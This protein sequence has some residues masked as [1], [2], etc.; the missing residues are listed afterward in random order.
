MIER[1]DGASNGGLPE[2]RPLARILAFEDE[3]LRFPKMDET[4]RA[5]GADM[6]G[7]VRDVLDGGRSPAEKAYGVGV[8]VHNYFRTRGI[9]LTSY[10]LRALANE[11]IEPPHVSPPPAVAEQEDA[12]EE[13]EAE[14]ATELVSFAGKKESEERVWAGDESTTSPP[15]VAEIAFAAPPS[16]LVNVVGREA[17]SFDRLLMKVVE[18]AAP[19]V[20]S[21]PLDRGLA[22]V[23]I[24]RT[25][26][27][28]LRRQEATLP[29]GMR[30][31]LSQM[32]FSEICG[33]GLLD[34]LWADR[35]IRAVYVDGPD[36]VYVERDGVREPAPETFRDAAHLLDIVRRLAR[37]ASSG[38]VDIQLRDGGIGLVIFPPAAPA[39]PVLMLHRGEPG[40]ATFD[41]LIAVQMLD[42]R[43]AALLGIAAR[44]RLNIVVL[45]PQGS[46]KTAMLAAI[47]R[48]L[49]SFR[50]V[51]LAA[52]RQ[53]SWPSPGKVELVASANGSPFSALMIAGARLKPDL[54]AVDA[55]PAGDIP[56][57]AARLSRG[58]RGTLVALR[59]DAM[60]AVL[61]RAADLTVRL[62]QSP[63]GLFRV[64]SVEDTAGASIFVHDG[65]RFHQLTTAPAFAGIVRE[66][67][68]GEA[69]S[70]IF[71]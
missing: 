24:D 67:G 4:W 66:A 9:T 12:K 58:G 32:A 31:R 40:S 17:A 14:T 11:L 8:I 3:D 49:S 65:H 38:V 36:Q 60:A 26:D 63:D 18:L 52:H 5:F 71:R 35:S 19:S 53:F 51:T 57:L 15:T 70:G 23:T 68:Y 33:L 45:G 59:P 37:P 42:R 27:E 62:G 50:V 28:V 22:R 20:G 61:A 1:P 43:M 48:D 25:I 54:L 56:A 46:G 30:Q 21:A 13:V 34:R 64:L 69:L 2:P 41:R 16:K 7:Q 44:A 47:A 10:E 55:P 29:A 39:G 6:G